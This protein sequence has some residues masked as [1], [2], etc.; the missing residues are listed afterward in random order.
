MSG[1]QPSQPSQANANEAWR[2]FTTR[3]PIAACKITGADDFKRL[4]KIINQK[5]FEHWERIKSRLFGTDNETNEQFEERLAKN[6]DAFIT[7]LTV[8]GVDGKVVSGHGEDFFASELMPENIASIA[9]DTSFSPT[10]LLKY[11]PTDRVYLLLDFTKP[12]P[13]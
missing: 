1:S 2:N 4:Y 5:Q 11:T 10:A 9:Y 3:T 12:P 6:R 13:L 8:T 7:T